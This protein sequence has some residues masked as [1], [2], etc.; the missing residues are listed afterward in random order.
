MKNVDPLTFDP[1]QY[2]QQL[3]N[4][5]LTSS[6]VAYAICFSPD[7]RYMLAGLSTGV[8]HVF[9]MALLLREDFWSSNAEYE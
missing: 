2:A 4:Q 6:A 9:D 7:G 5:T 3:R 8:V 1:R